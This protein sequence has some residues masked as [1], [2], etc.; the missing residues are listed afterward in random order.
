M[1][2]GNTEEGVQADESQKLQI[3]LKLPCCKKGKGASCVVLEV[4]TMLPGV[5]TD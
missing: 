5:G 3:Y 2:V 4:T 1:D